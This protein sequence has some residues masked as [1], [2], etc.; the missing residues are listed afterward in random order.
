MDRNSAGVGGCVMSA[1]PAWAR[2]GAKVVCI[3]DTTSSW[4]RS[5]TVGET[6]TIRA[7]AIDYRDR[8]GCWLEEIKNET[9]Q[10]AHDGMVELGYVLTRF[11]PLVSLESDITTHFEQF[12]HT[13][14]K[15]EERA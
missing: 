4:R 1:I 11:R 12:L 8:P 13:P 7:T 6:Y 9:V 2:V 3:S 14:Q 5:L 15:I 10:T